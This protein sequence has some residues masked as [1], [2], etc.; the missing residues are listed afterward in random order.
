LQRGGGGIG[1]L[2]PGPFEPDVHVEGDAAFAQNKNTVRKRN[3]FNDV[4]RDENCREA[5]PLPN[6]FGEL[7][8]FHARQGIERAVRLIEKQ[9]AGL[10]HQRARKG[11]ALP[12]PPGQDGRPVVF[13][14]LQTHIGKSCTRRFPPSRLTRDSYV[15]EHGLPGKKAGVLEEKAHIPL[16]SAH[17]SAIDRDLAGSGLVEPCDEAHQCSLTTA[18]AADYGN[19]LAG[20]NMEIDPLQNLPSAERLGDGA[21]VQGNAFD[22]LDVSWRPAGGMKPR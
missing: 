20:G 12:L 21:K 22:T 4:V 16:Q 13:T 1:V 5:M 7:V 6:A 17:R 10:A 3:R 8:H 2:V 15:A 18:G 14:A 19:E 9:N 11:D